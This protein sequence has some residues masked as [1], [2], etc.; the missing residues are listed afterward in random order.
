LPPAPTPG[1]LGLPLS[2][3]GGVPG[4]GLSLPGLGSLPSPLTQGGLGAPAVGVAPTG[5]GNGQGAG[6]LGTVLLLALGALAVS[7][8][9]RFKL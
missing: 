4:G 3:P 2:T 1:G 7:K 6:V 5:N 8:M 9:R